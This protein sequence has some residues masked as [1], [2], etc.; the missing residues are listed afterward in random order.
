MDQCIT[1]ESSEIFFFFLLNNK[2]HKAIPRLW[3]RVSFTVQVWKIGEMVIKIEIK[4]L[5]LQT[6]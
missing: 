6:D 2:I 5:L 4:W 1:I 3:E